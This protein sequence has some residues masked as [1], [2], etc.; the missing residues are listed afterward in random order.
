M[1]SST[2]S[3]TL[4]SCGARG[5][6]RKKPKAGWRPL[7]TMTTNNDWNARIRPTNR[8]ASGRV[9]TSTGRESRP[10]LLT[11]DGGKSVLVN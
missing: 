10:N 4:L 8:A 2:P 1:E 6:A 5:S 7:P 3:T 11:E 9:S